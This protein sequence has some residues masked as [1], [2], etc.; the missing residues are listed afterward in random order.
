MRFTSLFLTAL[1]MIFLTACCDRDDHVC[2]REEKRLRL[3][4]HAPIEDRLYP[5][6][7]NSPAFERPAKALLS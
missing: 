7:I 1:S 2:P 5:S 4:L 6:E 3:D